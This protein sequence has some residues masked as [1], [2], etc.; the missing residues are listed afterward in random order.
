MESKVIENYEFDS[1]EN[2]ILA[3]TNVTFK[4]AESG[5]CAWPVETNYLESKDLGAGRDH[6]DQPIRPFILQ[7]RTLRPIEFT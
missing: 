7:K 4:E 6:T 3:K 1:F 2:A 5:I